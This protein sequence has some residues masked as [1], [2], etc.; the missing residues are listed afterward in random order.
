M[1]MQRLF[2]PRKQKRRTGLS[3][4]LFS[5]TFL[6]VIGAASFVV[7][8]GVRSGLIKSAAPQVRDFA[9]NIG[10]LDPMACVVD[11]RNQLD[12]S[13][14][15]V[16]TPIRL[17]LGE[18]LQAREDLARERA[19]RIAA[20]EKAKSATETLR[21]LADS[22]Q[23]GAAVIA[24]ADPAQPGAQPYVMLPGDVVQPFSKRLTL[25]YR[26]AIDANKVLLG[27]DLWSGDREM[28]FYK[29]YH[30]AIGSAG[31]RTEFELVVSPAPDWNEGD[32]SIRL[33]LKPLENA[34]E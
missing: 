26:Q 1:T 20:E 28:E 29:P 17:V 3:F 23:A 16:G 11:A 30:A 14:D 32:R 25:V 12:C 6:C 22:M 7:L 34:T 15:A 21:R 8:I 33:E 18:L 24:A 9:L 27:S 31:E 19:Q 4:V 13:A 5:F 10:V 2:A